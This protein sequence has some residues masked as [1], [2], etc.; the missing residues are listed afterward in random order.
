M[1]SSSQS[2]IHQ[3]EDE[4]QQQETGGAGLTTSQHEDGSTD[5]NYHENLG[6]IPRLVSQLFK[7]LFQSTPKDSSVEYS[8]RCSFVEIYL[9][10]MTDLLHPGTDECRVRIG[11]TILDKNNEDVCVLGA[12]ELCCLCPED[13][14]AL[15]ARGQAARTKSSQDAN[16]DSSRSHAVFTL[17]LEQ[18]D[19]V[20][21]RVMHSR[22]LVIDCAGSQPRPTLASETDRATAT[23][24]NMINASFSSLH[25][26]VRWTLENQKHVSRIDDYLPTGSLSKITQL[27]RPSIG[28]TTQT[29]M[30]CTGAPSSYGI[31]DTIQ[32]LRFAQLVRQVKNEPRPRLERFTMHVYRSKLIQATRKEQQLTRLIRMMAQESKH[33]KKKTR[34]PKNPKVWEAILQIC[35][36]DKKYQKKNGSDSKKK[37]MK[38]S[39]DEI[40][41]EDLCISCYNESEQQ[42]EIQDLYTKIIELESNLLAE[43]TVREKAESNNRD[44]R[45]ELAALKSQN[46]SLMR[47]KR[48]LEEQL[49]DAKSETKSVLMQKAEVEHRLRTSMFRE[50]EAVLFLRQL[51]TFYFRLLK[52]KASQGSGGTKEAIQEAQKRLPGVADMEDLLDVDKMMVQSGIIE[53]SEIGADT[54]VADYCPSSEAYAK[55]SEEAEKA[56]EREI[57]MIQEELGN[58]IHRITKNEHHVSITNHDCLSTNGFTYGQL[59]A[60]RQKLAKTPAGLLAIQKEQELEQELAELSQKCI[61]LQSSINAEKAMVEALSGRQGAVNKMK[62]AQEVIMLKTELERR[63]NDLLA[64]VWKM[65]ELHLVNK[66]I[67]TK[68]GTREQHVSYLEEHISDVQAQTDRLL[69]QKEICEKKLR[70]ENERLRNKLKG[71]GVNLW[72]LGE[73]LDK[74]PV[75]RLSV[76]YTGERINLE[77]VPTRRLSTGDL[78]EE[79]I[80]NLVQVVEDSF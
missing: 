57:A 14:F 12:T 48:T 32:A 73:N 16:L 59:A 38:K 53:I 74:S 17:N 52:N 26:A 65:N 78:T 64:I 47:V 7:L 4:M 43:R 2:Q 35:D 20:T 30:I 58:D 10:K 40:E 66:T 70:E 25:N 72:Q 1:V 34:E 3:T 54:L 76:P 5:A 45:S 56:E 60:C 55:S 46:E 79:E 29:V 41:D 42:A 8:I 11:R 24:T 18:V 36:A 80:D 33:G 19:A 68:V 39:K 67:D 6:I 15:L 22:L 63:T 21:G 77:D 23:E 27:L 49:S 62:Q 31:D 75:W 9:E 51:R 28:G 69:L 61:G 71:M 50:S 44:I 37:K 13:V